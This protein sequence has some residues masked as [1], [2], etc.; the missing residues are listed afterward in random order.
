MST[1]IITASRNP[2]VSDRPARECLRCGQPR[3]SLIGLLR[4]F[5]RSVPSVVSSYAGSKA[6]LADL[7]REHLAVLGGASLTGS[8]QGTQTMQIKLTDRFVKSASTDGRKSQVFMVSEVI[9]FGVQ[10]R[11]TGSRC[12][13]ETDFC[14]S[15]RVSSWPECEVPQFSLQ[16]RSR[17]MSGPDNS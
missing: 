15:A 8:R 5:V 9:G 6:S 1:S 11:K 10:V 3:E 14:C 16:V 17:G 7:D 2:R 12:P 13:S 4:T